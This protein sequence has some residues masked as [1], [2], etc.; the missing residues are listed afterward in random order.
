MNR[1]SPPM[2]RDE[3]FQMSE[4]VVTPDQGLPVILRASDIEKRYGGIVALRGV[5]LDI[6]A[7]E[8]HAL[9]GENGAGKSTLAKIIA[10][11]QTADA[12]TIE[13][14]GKPVSFRTTQEARAAGIAIVL[15]EL[16][17]IPD[18]SV[19]EN[20]FLTHPDSYAGGL[21]LRRRE[22]NR[23]AFELFARLGWEHPVDPAR[24]V[25]ELSV[26][27]QQMVEILRALSW[28]A[29]LYILDEPTATLSSHE[30]DV[31]FGM[32]RRL[33]QQGV[34]FLL[35]THR[36]E[37]VFVLS[38]R[39]TVYRDGANSGAFQTDKTTEQELIR[40]MV[41]RDLGDFFGVRT[42][43]DPG[44]PILTV[45]N[46]C[47]GQRLRNCSIT[48]R[49][50]EVVGIAGLVGA[51]RTELIR[52]IFGA[53]KA[54]RGEVQL[55]GRAG[56][57][58]NPSQAIHESTAMVPEDRKAHGLLIDLP[59]SHNVAMVG[60]T[61][62]HGFW[63]HKRAEHDLMEQMTE[64]L[65]IKVADPQKPA[66]SLS[67]GNQQKIVLAKWLAID[68]DLLI[69]DEPTRGIDVG[70]KYEIYKLIDG[71]VA[72]GKA[73][74]L[75]SSELPEVLALS[76]RIVVMREGELV[77]E[78]THD[79]ADESSIL[80]LAAQGSLLGDEAEVA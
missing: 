17:L 42:R 54:D 44:E 22:I 63:L 46:L 67:G 43:S 55:R 23:R 65:Q 3:D 29:Q 13:W 41:G 36:L 73:V 45:T 51:G 30:V 7:G 33:K 61:T 4:P 27:E 25:S 19:A 78:L 40:A 18:L 52:A 34:S 79:E 31:L 1:S 8:V 57:I 68:P 32:I 59:I 74:L 69:L 72:Q 75:V 14:T 76:D 77:G 28:E 10:G 12:G 39:I 58:G 15:Q 38:D 11:V 49:R 26:A 20:I 21:F 53:D 80:A 56:L 24:K 62:G 60:L 6:R 71:L 47:R 64:H 48:V 16:N 35:V 50:G 70:T 2:T 37:E 66:G 5:D 9:M